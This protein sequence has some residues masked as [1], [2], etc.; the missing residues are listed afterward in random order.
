MMENNFYCLKITV[1]ENQD[2][3]FLKINRLP[4]SKKY[5]R[6]IIKKSSRI[7]NVL[8]LSV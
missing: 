6:N 3:Y 2:N 5:L 8:R 7:V 4:W 1:F